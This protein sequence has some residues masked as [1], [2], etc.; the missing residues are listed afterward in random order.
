[1]I[2]GKA[3]FKGHAAGATVL[4]GVRT[5]DDWE[6]MIQAWRAAL[7]KLAGRFSAGEAHPDPKKGELTCRQCDLQPLCRI[8]ERI[9]LAPE[10]S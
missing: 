6:P 10:D 2:T 7:E 1:V 9:E 4:P 5:K 8:E 3:V